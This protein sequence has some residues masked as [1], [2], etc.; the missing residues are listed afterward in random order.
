MDKQIMR[1]IAKGRCHSHK[2]VTKA[3][4]HAA[5]LC[6]RRTMPWAQPA[7]DA[8]SSIIDAWLKRYELRPRKQRHSAARVFERPSPFGR[9][10]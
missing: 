10:C 3:A 9:P 1:S 8:Y 6:Y 7:I 5:P 2:M 4:W